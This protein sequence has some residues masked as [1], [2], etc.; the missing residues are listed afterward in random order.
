MNHFIRVLPLVLLSLILSSSLRALA[1]EPE[2]RSFGFGFGPSFV[3]IFPSPA[4]AFHF[5]GETVF[6]SGIAFDFEGSFLFSQ[7]NSLF[8]PLGSNSFTS[9]S[10]AG[11]GSAAFLAAKFLYYPA[12][13]HSGF[14]SGL[15]GSLGEFYE[16]A[17]VGGLPFS[18]SFGKFLFGVYLGYDLPVSDIV[19]LNAQFSYYLSPA[20][21]P[22]IAMSELALNAKFRFKFPWENKTDASAELKP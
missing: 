3:N 5:D 19:S 6:H 20:G 10:Y 9:G 16:D 1:Y 22:F 12:D 14:Y 15:S 4:A 13:S 2:R 17:N 21:D 8:L 18:S 7:N 11:S